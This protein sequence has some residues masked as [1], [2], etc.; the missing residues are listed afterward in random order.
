MEGGK[1][2]KEVGQRIVIGYKNTERW[3]VLVFKDN[4][5]TIVN[6]YISIYY[7]CMTILGFELRA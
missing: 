3:E 5:V 1:S 7:I 2:R 4:R 6:I